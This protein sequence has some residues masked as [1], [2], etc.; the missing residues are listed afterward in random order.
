[1]KKKET[2][3]QCVSAKMFCIAYFFI[4]DFLVYLTSVLRSKCVCAL[5]FILFKFHRYVLFSF[6]F[7]ALHN[8]LDLYSLKSIT[9]YIF[10]VV[11]CTFRCGHVL[12]NML[13]R[14]CGG[15]GGRCRRCR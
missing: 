8:V 6:S 9:Q 4:V 15:G 1:M 5:A 10:F 2:Q 3:K 14:L 12:V 7:N 11:K 13:F